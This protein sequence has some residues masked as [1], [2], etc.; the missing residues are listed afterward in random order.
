MAKEK[1]VS[2]E[3]SGASVPARFEDQ[4]GRLFDEFLGRRWPRPFQWPRW[5]G[6]D[7]TMP[8]MDVVD[9]ENEVVVRAEL[10]GMSKDDIE[11][12]GRSAT[13]SR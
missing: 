2:I 1:N 7:A 12:I 6:L 4:M 10:P 9:R 13:P 11:R 8:P 3:Q 5:E